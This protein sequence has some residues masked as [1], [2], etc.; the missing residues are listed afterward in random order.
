MCHGQQIVCIQSFLYFFNR[1]VHFVIVS[2]D[3]YITMWVFSEKTPFV[4]ILRCELYMAT[5]PSL[6]RIYRF[7]AIW[8]LNTHS[9]FNTKVC[10]CFCRANWHTDSLVIKYNVTSIVKS[11]S[12]NYLPN[13]WII[14]FRKFS[15]VTLTLQFGYYKPLRRSKTSLRISLSSNF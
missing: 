4:F 12:F 8:T 3:H 11:S 7:L 9:S 1:F 6:P 5:Y 10:V 2:L 15:L 14:H 13:D